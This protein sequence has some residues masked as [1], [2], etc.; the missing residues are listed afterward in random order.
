MM[1]NRNAR[2]SAASG[3]AGSAAARISG[4]RAIHA[5]AGCPNLGKLRAYSVPERSARA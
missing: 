3:A 1:P 2:R 5:K 4:A